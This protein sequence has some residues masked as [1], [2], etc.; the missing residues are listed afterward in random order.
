[1]FTDA[2][3]LIHCRTELNICICIFLHLGVQTSLSFS[4]LVVLSGVDNLF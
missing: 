4:F 2:V 1:M 3:Y